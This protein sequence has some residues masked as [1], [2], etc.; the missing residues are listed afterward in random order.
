MQAALKEVP[1]G[2][3]G[4]LVNAFGHH[5]EFEMPDFGKMNTMDRLAFTRAF[6]AF[7]GFTNK[8][9]AACFPSL[10]PL[11]ELSPKGF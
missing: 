8:Q 10:R 7:R 5:L 6:D 9:M 1:N 3:Y 2:P 11:A 4:E